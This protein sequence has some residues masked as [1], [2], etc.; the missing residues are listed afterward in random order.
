MGILC[1]EADLE[2]PSVGTVYL[3]FGDR[4]CHWPETHLL[5]S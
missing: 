5:V 3:V 2:C 4:D 1:I